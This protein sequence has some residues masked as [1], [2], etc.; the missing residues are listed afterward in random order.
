[1]SRLG[2]RLAKLE[3]AAS[4]DRGSVIAVVRALIPQQGLNAWGRSL[5]EQASLAGC[6]VFV[7]ADGASVEPEVIVAPQ[8]LSEISDEDFDHFD[9]AISPGPRAII[10]GAGAFDMPDG[11]E[12]FLKCFRHHVGEALQ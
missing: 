4:D 2:S 5:V 1:M 9:A 3:T 8:P 10:F 7:T 6:C 12:A 11:F